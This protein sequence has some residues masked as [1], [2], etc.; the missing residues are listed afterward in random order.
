MS[1]L[2]TF[3]LP[4][5]HYQREYG[6]IPGYL[7]QSA[8]Y[9]ELQTS[10]PY[11]ECL[12]FVKKRTTPKN[13]KGMK[14]PVS[15]V[16]IQED[17]GDRRFATMGFMQF[18]GQVMK[19]EHRL[20]PALIAYRSDRRSYHGDFIGENVKMRSVFKKAMF[21]A[22]QEGDTAKA[23]ANDGEQENKKRNNNS[24]SG[25]TISKGTI[26]MRKSTH[27]SLTSVC[28]VA[29][30]TANSTNEKFLQGNRHYDKP[31]TIKTNILSIVE[32]TDLKALDQVMLK[33]GLH[34]PTAEEA[35][36]VVHHSSKYYFESDF[37][38][39]LIF[40]MLSGLSP[41]ERAAFV[42]V[43][44]LY[45]L[46]K[47]NHDVVRAIITD[48]AY[49]SPTSDGPNVKDVFDSLDE[50]MRLLVTFLHHDES[51]GVAVHLLEESAPE[52]IGKMNA[53]GR[54][55]I[56]TCQK[57][58][59]FIHAFFLPG[60]L[61]TNIYAFP[62]M[63]RKV[64]PVSDTD[65]TI[66]TVG[67]WVEQM[68]GQLE[69]TPEA[70]RIVFAIVFIITGTV[71]HLLAM[72]SNR[73]GVDKDLMRLLS[74]KN[75][76]YFSVFVN[77]TS[78]KHYFAS[79]DAREGNYFPKG[80]MEIKGVGLKDSTLPKAVTD[81]A[82]E[83]M[84]SIVDDVKAGRG[85]DIKKVLVEL[86]EEERKIIKET[87]EGNLRLYRNVVINEEN[88]YEE[89]KKYSTVWL[90]HEFWNEVMAPKYGAAPE[91][92][93]TGIT[94]SVNADNKTQVRQWMESI[95]DKAL[96][97]RFAVFLR[98]HGKD[99]FT[100]ISIPMD[101]VEEFGVPPEIAVAA[102]ARKAISNN[103]SPF[104]L[105]LESFGLMFRNKHNSRLISDVY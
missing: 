103:F 83:L 43:G 9:L 39:K 51:E 14:D 41:V 33:Y 93:Y 82:N 70:R 61:P 104:Y 40:K 50:D 29:T 18:M 36:Q 16:A 92:P 19:H 98:K 64:V 77:T 38:D 20:S 27:P 17:N 85:V 57:Y 59:D 55:L 73:M 96:A 78:A 11:E 12:E 21:K 23:I 45:H 46:N 58:K 60:L 69:F 48:L 8:R 84:A 1:E 53:T 6:I 24:Y 62:T 97:E 5:D 37:Q 32:A 89:D 88:T 67:Y 4:D 15:L 49:L 26:L 76:Y 42:Y 10:R 34:Y 47:F 56:E 71:A 105:I 25:A 28:R 91:P 3:R 79:Q 94:L 35:F 54:A 13:P 68:L 31:D 90:W 52:L 95:E 101:K 87:D 80:K 22:Q 72:L 63:R 99:K 44:D 81:R 74:M 66:F 75:E 7:E 100:S 30:S 86:A 102:N 2:N 65:S